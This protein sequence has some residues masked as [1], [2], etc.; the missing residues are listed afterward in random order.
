[1][2]SNINNL[3]NDKKKNKI[4]KYIVIF[5]KQLSFLINQLDFLFKN[6]FILQDFYIEKMYLLNDI[7]SKISNLELFSEK[8][9]VNKSL[10]ENLMSEINN[11]FEKICN[12]IGSNNCKNTLDIY[13]SNEDYLNEQNNEFKLIFNLYN[14]FFIPLSSNKINTN[15]KESFLN[16]HNIK[17]SDI[18]IVIKIIEYTKANPLIEI[19]QGTTIVFFIENKIIY[20]NGYFI[21]D[22]LNI[23]K[24]SLDFKI[25]LINIEEQLDYIDL[26]S[27]FKEKYIDQLPLKDFI[28]LTPKEIAES[29]KNDY[30]DFLT[31]KNKSLS[32]LIKEFVKCNIQKQRKIILLFLIYNEESQFTAHI[33]FDLI[34]DKSFLADSQYLSEVL[35]NSLHWKIQKTF[36]LSNENFENNK[37]KLENLTINNVSYDSRIFALQTTENIK[38]KGMEKLKEINGSKENSIKAQQWLDGFLKIPFNIFK[39]ELIIDFFKNYQ[40]LIEKYI[41][42]F[43]IRISEYILNKLN[44]KNQ[45]IYNIII[46]I[47]DEYHSTL[48]KSENSYN[49]FIKYI[50]YIKIRIENELNQNIEKNINIIKNLIKNETVIEDDNLFLLDNYSSEEITNK[51]ITNDVIPNEQTIN[52]CINQ[53]SYFKKIKNDLFENNIINKNN[54]GTMVKKLHELECMLNVNLVKNETKIIENDNKDKYNYNFE[55]FILKNLDE[56]NKF[57]NDWNDFKLKKK[58]YMENIDKILDKCTYGQIDAKNQ[59]KRIIGQWMNGV[60]KGQCFGLHGPPGVGKTTLCKNGLAKCLFDENGESRP[61]AFLPLGGATN[62]S[63]LEGHHY[64]YMGSTWGK[65]IDILIETKCMNPIIYID[66]LDKISK[67]EH[68]KEITSILTHITDQSQNKEYYDRYFASIPIDLSQVLFIFSY[69]D[70]DNID[71]VL[72]DRIQEI[73]IKPLSLKEKLVISQN[74]IIPEILNNVGFSESEIILNNNILIKII[75]EYTFEAGVRKL[76]EILYDIIRDINLKKITDEKNISYPINID[77]TYICDFLSN[78]AKMTIKKFHAIPRVGLVN[79]LYATKTGLG[80]LTIIQVMRI[81]SDKKFTLEKLT[82]CQ[83]D[84]MKESMNCAMT[85]AWNIIPD[86]IRKEINELKDGFGLHIHCPEG[87]TPKDGPS[88]G[89]A[90]T[91]G[92]ISRLTNIPIRNDIALTGEVDLIGEAHEIGGLYS[93]LGGAHNSEIKTVLIPRENKKDLDIILKKEDE[94]NKNIFKILNIKNDNEKLELNNNKI[95]FRNTLE[96]LIVDNIFDVL[97]YGLVEND[98]IFNKDF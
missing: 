31:Y 2:N 3:K 78:M 45:N 41:D 6:K 67:T 84:V 21:N 35:F 90:I 92:I 52:N 46:Q 73:D 29:I 60:S 58:E 94:E 61:F 33:I 98:L 22:T 87:G 23:F 86:K 66:E 51:I 7:Q 59:M 47:I 77:E 71:R 8:K 85:L 37:K 20:I 44:N 9:K 81:N 69:N 4:Y 91:L 50:Q 54:L 62:G 43:T 38:A 30:D 11:S 80:G 13:L 56:F 68:G 96:I 40:I 42:S 27:D 19:I 95:Y 72:R 36:K 76:N 26:P 14:D 28:I 79:G 93:K 57:I 15:E 88:A 16:K 39:K 75:N 5:N 18:P 12:K 89:L 97:K 53:L 49:I 70:K 34:N 48:Y 25:K 1:M 32:I 10:I 65:I 17:E 82:G 55:N 64:T 83:G 24:N 74:Y 63:I